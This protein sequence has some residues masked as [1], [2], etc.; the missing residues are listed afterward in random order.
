MSNIENM[1]QTCI[2]IL[3]GLAIYLISR[4]DKWNKYG[5]VVGLCGQVFWFYETYKNSQ[6]GMFL[7]TCFY[8]YSYING[9]YLRFYKK[10]KHK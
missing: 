9:I 4:T 8:T 1:I 3:S 6:W 5:F 2:F 7:L 10:E